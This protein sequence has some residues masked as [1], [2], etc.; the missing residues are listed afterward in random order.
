MCACAFFAVCRVGLCEGD[1]GLV[2]GAE[3]FGGRVK[4][5]VSRLVAVRGGVW[6]CVC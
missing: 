3:A 2:T 5:S 6:G 4:G 1:C